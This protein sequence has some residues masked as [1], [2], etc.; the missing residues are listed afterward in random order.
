LCR[1]R[2]EFDPAKRTLDLSDGGDAVWIGCPGDSDLYVAY[3]FSGT[4][5]ITLYGFDTHLVGGTAIGTTASATGA[6]TLDIAQYAWL[7]IEVTAATAGSATVG[8]SREGL[9]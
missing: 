4:G 7:K 9:H 5:T 6:Q 8:Y 1:E 3:A 2:W